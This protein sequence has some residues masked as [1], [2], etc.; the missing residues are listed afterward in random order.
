MNEVC[1]RT[2]EPYEAGVLTALT[3]RS[4]AHWGY[5]QATL[6]R[7]AGMLSIS[8]ATIR[9]GHVVVA[10]RDG[11]VTGYY[12]IT[13]EPPHGELADL[14]LEPEAIGTGLG[15]TLW[16]HAVDSAHSAG[17]HTLTLESD[18]H[19]E[20][21]YLRMGAERIG[22]REVAPGRTLPVLRVAF[23]TA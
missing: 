16:E 2:A 12:Q 7:M 4:K 20:G 22:E 8:S 9:D 6:D 17:F 21:F 3:R 11:V 13:G 15:R 5:P 1:L 19:A 23:H 14:F 10:E 18:P